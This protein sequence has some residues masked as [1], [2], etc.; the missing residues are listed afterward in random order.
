[1]TRLVTSVASLTDPRDR[2]ELEVTL[3]SVI[4]DLIGPSTLTMWRLVS[5]CGEPRLRQRVR[6]IAGRRPFVSDEPTESAEL[7]LLEACDWLRSCYETRVPLRLGPSNNLQYRHVF[8]VTNVRDVIG[9]LEFDYPTPL[10]EYQDRLITGLLHIYRNHLRAIDDAE[11]DELTGLLNRK[12]FDRCFRR[13]V[14]Q[15]ITCRRISGDP[16]RLGRRRQPDADRQ[17]WLAVA[18]IDFFK[19]IND[20]FGHPYGDEVLVLLAR[21]MRNLFRESDRIFRFGGEEFVVILGPT[22]PGAAEK[23]LERCRAAVE[24][25]DF[26]QVGRVTISIGYTG[27]G[28]D[29][30]GSDAF[31]RADAALYVAKKQ[32]RNKVLRHENLV[33]EGALET[34]AP[35]GGSVEL[36]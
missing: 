21:L 16:E 3:A 25:F 24:A 23:T 29:D 18:D 2:D 26:P 22:E 19:S 5:H 17:L 35:T 4:F 6:A 30:S 31:G 7:P 8:P 15:E 14:S 13:G 34:R 28:Y 33:A 36:F 11:Y 20:R 1:M 10:R 12:T 9:L 32:G 27:I